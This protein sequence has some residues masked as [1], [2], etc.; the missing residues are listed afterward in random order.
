[1]DG[2]EWKACAS[3]WTA[4]RLRPGKHTFEVRAR[5][6]AGWNDWSPAV[7]AFTVQ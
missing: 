5:D 1:M 3:G 4:P 2:G 6:R 7:R